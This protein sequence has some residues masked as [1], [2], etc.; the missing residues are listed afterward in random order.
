[1]NN[2]LI[3]TL[4]TILLASCASQDKA[5]TQHKESTIITQVG[6]KCPDSYY[7][8]LYDHMCHHIDVEI[9]EYSTVSTYQ[10]SPERHNTT[11]LSLK[12]KTK[13]NVHAKRKTSQIDC[14][15][16]LSDI[17]KCSAENL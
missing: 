16:V 10:L 5:S 15:Q 11:F 7:Y 14:K 8:N 6:V 9:S 2:L 4:S 1:M 3:I 13:V 12:R 17:N